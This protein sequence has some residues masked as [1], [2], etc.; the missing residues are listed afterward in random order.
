MPLR[1]LTWKN[2]SQSAS[3]MSSNATGSKIPRLFTRISTEGKRRASSSVAA[4]VLRSAAN[5]DALFG[6]IAL[7]VATAA[8]TDSVE[9]PFHD[10]CAISAR[11]L[12]RCEI[13][14]RV[15]RSRA[16]FRS[17]K[18]HLVSLLRS[19]RRRQGRRT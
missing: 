17:T 11:A 9:R 18:I 8:S 1:T 14:F 16:S 4:A 10:A 6:A 19:S 13:G 3:V 5:P 7:S 15:L 12:R 2:R